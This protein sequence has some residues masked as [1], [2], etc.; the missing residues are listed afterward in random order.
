MR[1]K[2]GKGNTQSQSNRRGYQEA[3]I[4]LG[5]E[6]PTR[7]FYLEKSRTAAPT[8]HGPAMAPAR[9][10][11]TKNQKLKTSFTAP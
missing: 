10:F 3:G 2:R 9:L 11:F 5:R 4:K 6:F 8:V 1:A 7:L